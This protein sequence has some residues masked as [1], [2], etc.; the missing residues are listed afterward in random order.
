MTSNDSRVGKR[1]HLIIYHFMLEK[2][3]YNDILMDALKGIFTD[4]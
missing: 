2:P 1:I 4:C 3:S